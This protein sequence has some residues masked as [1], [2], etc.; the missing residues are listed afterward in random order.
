MSA[1]DNSHSRSG[2]KGLIFN[3]QP[4]SIHDGPGIRTTVFMK[5]CPLICE[6]CENPES[7]NAFEEIMTRDIKCTRCGRCIE[8][9][10]LGAITI[11]EER[12]KIDRAKC[13]LCLECANACPN[14]ALFI[15]GEF[16]G[17]EE[18]VEEVAKDSLFYRISGGGVT[19]S[20]GEPL[21]QSEFV[22][23][24]LKGLKE[25]GIHTA[26]DTTGFAPWEKM[27]GVLEYVDL[28]LFDLKHVDPEIHR[29]RTGV[30]NEL[31]L[32]NL[33][34]T[35]YKAK[36]WVRVPVIPCFNDSESAIQQIAIFCSTLPVEK[37][38]LLP[39]HGWAET[40]YEALGRE[41]L[42]KAIQSHSDERMKELCEVIMAAGL[43]CTIKY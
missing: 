20:G 9:C 23:Q 25:K 37:L 34:K 30:G 38:S 27:E 39:Y 35:A 43:E 13:N 42:M 1:L 8:A 36:T 3:I 28:V 33:Q 21:T 22:T 5:G 7:Q 18:I 4:L 16:K 29:Q 10:S 2:E 40:K 41:F 24:V 17:V 6:W 11:D 32:H 15:S 26:L 12:R 14:G 31:I 19:I